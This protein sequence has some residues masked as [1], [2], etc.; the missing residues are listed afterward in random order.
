MLARPATKEK[1]SKV[2]T[3]ANNIVEYSTCVQ[4]STE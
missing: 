4:V 1:G 3:S 2:S